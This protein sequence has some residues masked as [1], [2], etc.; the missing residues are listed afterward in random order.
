MP[1]LAK[2]I[3][4]LLHSDHVGDRGSI[5][6]PAECDVKPLIFSHCQSK[7]PEHLTRLI[8]HTLR[9]SADRCAGTAARTKSGNMSVRS[10]P[11][12]PSKYGPSLSIYRMQWRI[13]AS[14]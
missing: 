1:D 2:A 5:F 13:V 6:L 7:F 8:K 4:L 14:S 12:Q 10:F 3:S 11:A 9:T